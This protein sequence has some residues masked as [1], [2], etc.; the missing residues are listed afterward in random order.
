MIIVHAGMPKTG[1]TALQD[2]LCA[3]RDQ[4]RDAGIDYPALWGG[5]VEGHHDIGRRL[6]E[7]DLSIVE[8]IRERHTPGLDLVLSTET[9]SNLFTVE[10]RDRLVAFLRGL[11]AIDSVHLIVCLRRMDEFLEAMYLQ[12]VRLGLDTG[13]VNQYMEPRVDW[14][15]EVIGELARL[16]AD[17]PVHRTTMLALVPGVDTVAEVAAAMGVPAQ[18]ARSDRARRN[19]RLGL[20]ATVALAH[21]DLVS[22]RIGA[23][24]SI[25]QLRTAFESG[26]IDLVDDPRDLHVVPRDLAV[27]VFLGSM[28]AAR[29]GGLDVYSDA[30]LHD[31]VDDSPH[32]DLDPS[33]LTDDDMRRIEAGLGLG[34]GPAKRVASRAAPGV[35]YLDTASVG[36]PPAAAVEALR[37]GVDAW[38]VGAAMPPDYDEAIERSRSAYARIVGCEPDW[39]AIPTPVSVAT[40]QA[41][42]ALRPGD[43]VLLAEEDFTSVLFPFLADP[44]IESVV[45]PLDL[46]V[47]R[48][49]DDIAMVAVSA[50][51]S[52]DGRIADLDRLAA[53]CRATGAISYV[54]TTQASGWLDFDASR[55]DLTAAGAYKWL[56]C[57]RG[58]GFL[59]VNPRVGERMAAL[60]PGW[61][62]G[63]QPW[64]T[65]YRPPYRAAS[66]ARKF[67]VSPAWLPF[68]GAAPALEMLADIGPAAVGRHGIDLANRFRSELGLA[69]GASPIVSLDLTTA[70][71]ERLRL[72]GVRFASRDGRSRFSFHLCNTQMDVDS[73]LDAILVE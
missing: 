23:A 48:I 44:T 57:P 13:T 63:E 2:A 33:L 26:L 9:L 14:A 24:I 31:L 58:V 45:V 5:E 72:A 36:V 16:R 47:E 8:E 20:R 68:V 7:D 54:D 59:T 28:R 21:V 19:R 29:V 18:L 4:L 11:E 67:D 25:D 1:T 40:A 27:E 62:S 39:V 32:H 38:A 49:D 43:K 46:L 51:Q 22:E 15:Q 56:M 52:A 37:R 70:Q 66:N 12:H 42:T 69:A 64:Q 60:A 65:V 34:S 6:L 61:Y 3:N 73:A 41:K 55:F 35:V 71:V 10:H 17:P 30:Y 53:A 50:V